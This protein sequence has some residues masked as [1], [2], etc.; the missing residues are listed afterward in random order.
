MEISMNERKNLNENFYELSVRDFVW[1]FLWTSLK[2]LYGNFHERA[3]RDYVSMNVCMRKSM[4]E[5][6][7]VCMGISMNEHKRVCMEISMNEHKRVCMGISMNE[8]KRVC[9][10]ISMNEHKR[11]CMEISMN[12][13][14]ETMYLWMFVWE[15]LWTS[16][17][18]FVWDFYELSVLERVWGFLWTK[19]KGF[20]WNFYELSTRE[21]CNFYEL[22]VR[23]FVWEPQFVRGRKMHKLWSTRVFYEPATCRLG[24]SREMPGWPGLGRRNTWPS[25]HTAHVTNS[26]SSTVTFMVIGCRLT[27]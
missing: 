6:K 3:L 16:I 19:L 5:H 4:N 8:H 27:N 23:E 12:E 17:R 1:E 14:W 13:P 21:Y 7:R 20:V 25:V 18:E 15:S 11:V 2:S 26:E 10:G 22:G 9:M 24:A